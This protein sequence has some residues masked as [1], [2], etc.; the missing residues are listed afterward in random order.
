MC[1]VLPKEADMRSYPRQAI[2]GTTSR[3]AQ[4]AACSFF[5]IWCAALIADRRGG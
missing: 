4:P 5:Q 2:V 3:W 1:S